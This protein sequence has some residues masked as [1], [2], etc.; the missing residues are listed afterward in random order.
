MSTAPPTP[1]I[2]ESKDHILPLR[3]L[4]PRTQLFLSPCS[5]SWGAL[6]IPASWMGLGQGPCC[7]FLQPKG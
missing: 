4:G 7:L 3:T 1:C 2:W 6:V 5:P